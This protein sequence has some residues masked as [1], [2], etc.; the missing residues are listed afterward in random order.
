MIFELSEEGLF[1]SHV[2]PNAGIISYFPTDMMESVSFSF[3]SKLWQRQ[4]EN[5]VSG[6]WRDKILTLKQTRETKV[7]A[8]CCLPPF[9]QADAAFG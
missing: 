8:C 3:R 1:E 6:M 7:E 9:A 2:R 4:I 5:A